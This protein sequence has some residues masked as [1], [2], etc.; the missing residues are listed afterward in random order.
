MSEQ[1]QADGQ[2]GQAPSQ[3]QAF[4]QR[5]AQV[6]SEHGLQ[7]VVVAAAVPAAGGFGP[8]TVHALSWTHGTPPDEWKKG[9]AVGLADVAVKAAAAL[10]PKTE[11]ASAAPAEGEAAPEVKA[12][13]AAPVAA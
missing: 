6:A 11:T 13:D 1:K 9:A 10:A 5:V 4:V 12:E 8:S 2:Q 3:F 7:A